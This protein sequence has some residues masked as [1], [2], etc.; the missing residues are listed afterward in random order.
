MCGGLLAATASV[1]L[2]GC[3]YVLFVAMPCRRRN[4]EDHPLGTAA[5]GFQGAEPEKA[6][7]V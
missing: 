5:P 6:V 7:L 4:F 2:H 3:E 1:P